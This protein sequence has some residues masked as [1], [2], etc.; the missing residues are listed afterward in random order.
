MN[1]EAI[2]L[3]VYQLLN[4]LSNN[5]Y[6]LE[7]YLDLHWEFRKSLNIITREQYSKHFISIK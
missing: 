3:E 5:N 1:I 6:P 4:V 7:H 2:D